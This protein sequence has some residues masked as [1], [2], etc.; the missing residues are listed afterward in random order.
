MLSK[1][2]F[3]DFCELSKEINSSKSDRVKATTS[4]LLHIFCACAEFIF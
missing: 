4:S 2:Q 3:Y 1:N